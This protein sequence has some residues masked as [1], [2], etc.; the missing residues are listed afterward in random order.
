MKILYVE[1]DSRDADLVCRE[2][3]RSS[4]HTAIEVAPT[5]T[6]ARR[7]LNE[8]GAIYDLVLIDL[9]LPDGTGL[10]LLEEIREQ[11]KSLAVVLLT[12]A[13]DEETAVAALKAG[14]DDYVAKHRDYHVRLLPTLEAALARFRNHVARRTRSLRVLYAE[15]NSADIDLTQHHLARYARHIHIDVVYTALDALQR[16]LLSIEDQ[17]PY[18]VLLL[19]YQLPGMNA[20]E[21][22]KTVYQEYRLSLPTVLVTGRGDEEI[23]VQAL[24]LGAANYLV[25][26]PGY[27]FKLPV[28]LENAYYDVEL[29]R[30]RARLTESEQRFRLLA[31]NARDVIYRFRLK[32]TPAFEYVSPSAVAITGYTP[33]EHYAD[34][35]LGFKLVHPDD[36]PLL[37]QVAAGENFGQP[38]ILRWVRKDG[39][40]I[41]TEQHNTPI[42]N[43][44]GELVAI[45]GIARDITL[46][47]KAQEKL[48]ESEESFRLLFESNPHPMWVYDIETLAFLEVNNSAVDHYGYSY[49]EFLMMRLPDIRPPEDVARLLEDT[50]S[51]RPTLQHSGE[52]RH[53]LKNG[54][55]IDVEITSHTLE[56]GGRR[57]ALVVAQDITER[58]QARTAEREQRQLAEALRD[59]AAALIS[60]LDLKTVMNAILENVARV[61]PH[62]AANIMLIEKDQARPV[63]WRGYHPERTPLLQAFRVS[64]TDTPNLHLMFVTGS[65]FLIPDTD[66]F[67]DWVHNPLTDRVKSYVAAPIRSHEQVIGFLNLDSTEPN[68]FTEVHAQRLQ[69][70]A[71]QASLAI[72]HAQLYEEIQ[73]H[74]RELEQRVSERTA[75]L[76]R[77]EAR[78]RAIVDDQTDLVCRYL[79]GGILTF[80]NQAY[81]EN[82]NR[83]PEEL[84][85]ISFFD[86][87]PNRASVEQVQLQQHIASLSPQN[88]VASIEIREVTPDGQVRWHHWVDRILFD[89]S[90]SFVEYQSVGHDITQRKLAEDQLHQMLDHA[91]KLSELRSR[92]MS[93]AAHDLRNPL[94]VIQSGISMIQNYSDRLTDEQKQNKYTQINE[95][96]KLMVAMLDDVLTIGQTESGK[97]EFN[98]IHLDIVAFCSTIVE[99][100]KPATDSKRKITF[101]S[102]GDCDTAYLDP[103]LLRHILSNLLSNAIK[104]SPDDTE[105]T[106]S[107]NCNSDQTTFRIQDRGIGIPKVE[108][109][110]LFEAFH[111]ASNAKNVRGTGLGLAIVKQ[112]VDLHGG[113]ITFDSQE[114]VGTTFTVTLPCNSGGE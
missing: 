69:A 26:N 109:A 18:D 13:G 66:Q 35:E 24:R 49:D 1:D 36:R 108:Q 57:A 17:N 82:F 22:L 99:E 71:D 59:S 78:Y 32:P 5:L 3:Q 16:L 79:P 21:L 11:V 20:L 58:K 9:K 25:K 70:F 33:E 75:E 39:T 113:K 52:W 97:V 38:L 90:G 29:E 98:P 85:G 77:S 100:L 91:M 111:R 15:H 34:P 73:R 23:A 55:I 110:R 51:K 68:F 63:Y 8:P 12:G 112:S 40:V 54:Q 62:D 19:D 42:Y 56:F 107:L 2:L 95:T 4:P 7:R 84:L 86:L 37:A 50:Q 10:E 104:Y 30:E 47:Q 87:L 93:M 103:K 60:A 81:C 53:R 28:I 114:G 80:V 74:A 41:W 89:E 94:A 43:E 45:E 92:Y 88:P 72:E 48:R 106:F 105:V 65:P 46:R 31:E 76:Q 102:Q 61:V 101:S 96:I 14:A 67:S 6:E 27:L 64:I 83:T 44:H